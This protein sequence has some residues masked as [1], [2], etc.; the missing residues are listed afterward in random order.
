MKKQ[1]K[2]IISGIA[3]MVVTLIAGFTITTLSLNIFDNMSTNQL[4]LLFLVDILLLI[5]CAAG[6]WYFF[7]SKKMKEKKRT[8]YL[9][10]RDRRMKRIGQEV[11]EINEIINFANFAA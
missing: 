9:K 4:R 11:Q 1:F 7:E 5:G 3:I 10:R 6:V 2:Q 8:A